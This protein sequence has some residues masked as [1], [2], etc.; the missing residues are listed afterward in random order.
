MGANNEQRASLFV[1]R[2]DRYNTVFTS[3]IDTAPQNNY[4]GSDEKENL[5]I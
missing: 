5:K 1:C 4:C 2:D 3:R